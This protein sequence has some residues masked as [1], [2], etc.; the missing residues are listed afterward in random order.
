MGEEVFE[1]VFL[2][3]EVEIAFHRN[4]ERG[5]CSVYIPIQS[6]APVEYPF[7]NAIAHSL[8]PLAY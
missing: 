2:V 5:L 1:S 6:R 3:A 4:L 8:V 7:I